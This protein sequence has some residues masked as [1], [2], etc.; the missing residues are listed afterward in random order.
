MRK[1]RR[2]SGEKLASKC[3]YHVYVSRH[4]HPR[5]DFECTQLN[6][7]H[8]SSAPTTPLRKPIRPRFRFRVEKGTYPVRVM[9]GRT[10]SRVSQHT[11]SHTAHSPSTPRPASMQ[12]A[13][14]RWECGHQRKTFGKD[15]ARR[16]NQPHLPAYPVLYAYCNACLPRSPGFVL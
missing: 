9:R 6:S 4:P 7:K 5:D 8:L 14:V 11:A 12:P 2:P 3:N 1:L 13:A 16:D 10:L 15:R